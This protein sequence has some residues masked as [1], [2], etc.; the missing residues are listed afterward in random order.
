MARTWDLTKKLVQDV[1]PTVTPVQSAPEKLLTSQTAAEKQA[2]L[3]Q[4][5]KATGNQ[6]YLTPSTNQFG[7][8][9][10]TA[11]NPMTP[12]RSTVLETPTTPTPANPIVPVSSTGVKT[13]PAV[14][15]PINI[16]NTT[17]T[18]SGSNLIAPDVAAGTTGYNPMA[19]ITQASEMYAPVYQDVQDRIAAETKAREEQYAKLKAEAEAKAIE[20]TKQLEAR[21][22]TSIAD[23]ERQGQ[24]AIEAA[25]RN[26]A[27]SGVGRSTTAA[28]II[29][30]L[31]RS[32]QA[33]IADLQ[34][35]KQNAIETMK[36]DLVSSIDEQLKPF[37]EQLKSLRTEEASVRSE[38]LK[39]KG[40]LM[41]EIIKND[42]TKPTNE[43]KLANG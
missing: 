18:Q 20:K 26:L 12:V 31:G 9:K 19:Q 32:T 5:A 25:Q 40:D 33:Q 3:E 34:F 39:M 11:E 30:D 38:E 14:T 29:A 41:K 36:A 23:I 7:Q 27:F 37:D 16:Y 13:T 15:T 8:M 24:S 10:Y 21:Y 42:P 1:E 6:D 4:L 17:P 28:D 43:L 35:Q 2:N 22:G